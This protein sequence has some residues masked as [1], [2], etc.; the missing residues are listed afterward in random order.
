M[1][2]PVERIVAAGGPGDPLL[3]ALRDGVYRGPGAAWSDA[4]ER[5]YHEAV[6]R[7]P[8][9]TLRAA[10]AFAAAGCV[11]LP[12]RSRAM[13]AG[14]LGGAAVDRARAA[15][16]LVSA[17][18]SCGETLDATTAALAAAARTE[19][20]PDEGAPVIVPILSATAPAIFAGAGEERC[21]R[22]PADAEALKVYL[23]DF[24]GL[25]RA[26]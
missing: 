25:S 10:R 7:H 4:F 26:A 6:G 9:E 16:V 15:A 5:L 1:G 19:E 20:R 13:L 3:A 12:P 23:R 11:D 22:M 8:L 21:S 24:T 14:V 2:A 17:Q 18:N